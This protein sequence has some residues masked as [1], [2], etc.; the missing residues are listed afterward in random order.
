MPGTPEE[1]Q[2][3]LDRLGEG[4]ESAREKAENDGLLPEDDPQDR[5]PTLADPD[6]DSSGDEG[7]PGPATG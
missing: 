7:L 2:E 1:M 3:R 4:I 5:E 6:P